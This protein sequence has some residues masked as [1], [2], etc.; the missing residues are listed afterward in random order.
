LAPKIDI[1]TLR[2]LADHRT[3][4]AE[5]IICQYLSAFAF[6]RITAFTPSTGGTKPGI[7]ARLFT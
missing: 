7:S 4:A 2:K 1:D 6:R 5:I 3:D